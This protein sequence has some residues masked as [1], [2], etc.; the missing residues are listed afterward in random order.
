M[1][2]QPRIIS[3]GNAP[4]ENRG[5]TFRSDAGCPT[6][7]PHTHATDWE[8]GASYFNGDAPLDDDAPL[9]GHCTAPTRPVKRLF[10]T[11]TPAREK[12]APP[13][14]HAMRRSSSAFQTPFETVAMGFR[15]KTP[16]SALEGAPPPSPCVRRRFSGG[17]RREAAGRWPA[18]PAARSPATD[19]APICAQTAFPVSDGRPR[20][21][22][23]TH[24]NCRNRTGRHNR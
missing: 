3:T 4:A 24:R 20:R 13:P 1:I 2:H 22:R 17:R 7:C 14:H 15:A 21:G 5:Q 8:T 23:D 12:S 18:I 16:D 6:A 9:D 19:A 11:R 10:R